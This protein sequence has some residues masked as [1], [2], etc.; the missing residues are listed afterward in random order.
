MRKRDDILYALIM[1]L[2]ML[3][4]VSGIIATIYVA[5]HFV[6]KYW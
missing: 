2:A 5:G 4:T 3:L 6:Q 1:V